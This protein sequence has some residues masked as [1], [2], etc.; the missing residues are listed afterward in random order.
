MA[1]R[2]GRQDKEELPGRLVPQDRAALQDKVA[3]EAP[4]DR[5]A[6]PGSKGHLPTS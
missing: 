2:P 4:L 1:G 3:W 5:A 6:P